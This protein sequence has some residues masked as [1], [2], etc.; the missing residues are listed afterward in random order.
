MKFLPLAAIVA[1]TVLAFAL[2]PSQSLACACGCNVFDVGTGSMLP[3]DTGGS[4]FVEYDFMDQTRNW[5][6][7]SSAVSAN[8]PDKQIRTNFVTAGVQYMVNR[9]WGVMAELPVWN[10]EFRTEN[11]AATA[12][13]A[14]N[15]T[16]FGD[17]R[18]SGVYTGLSEDMSTGLILGVKLPTGDWKYRG[19][20][21]DTSI[22]SG[23]TDIL[24]GGYHR[25]PLTG[26]KRWTYFAQV[27]G[28]LTVSSQG[29][30]RPG[31]SVDGAAGVYYN[32][33]TLT[34]GRIKIAPVLQVIGSARASDSGPASNTL[35]SGFT[36]V[37]ISPGLEVSGGPWRIYGDV[38]LPIYQNVRGNQLTAPALFK[39]IVSHSF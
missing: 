8:N 22:G 15:H 28:Q 34:G 14:F 9:S 29:G 38:E 24:V 4:A 30:Y 19:F 5:S 36:R 16:A 2:S 12:V 3:T 7:A 20:D 13:D 33:W 27:Q 21:R 11:D 23:S 25:G 1:A 37:L 6:G 26:D 35:N 18:I 39:M 10:R 17:I 31:D 32:G